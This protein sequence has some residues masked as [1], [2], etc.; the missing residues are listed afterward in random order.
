[1][2]KHKDFKEHATACS[3]LATFEETVSVN[4][5]ISQVDALQREGATRTGTFLMGRPVADSG[6]LLQL[7]QLRFPGVTR[8]MWSSQISKEGS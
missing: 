4:M 2:G 8:V 5:V 7:M 6:E 1:M 3:N